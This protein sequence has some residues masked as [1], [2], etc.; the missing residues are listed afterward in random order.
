MSVA[1]YRSRLLDPVEVCDCLKSCVSDG[2]SPE[3][4]RSLKPEACTNR[5]RDYR[6]YQRQD[7]GVVAA[8][9]GR[10]KI[11]A[12]RPCIQFRPRRVD[13]AHLVMHVSVNGHRFALLPTLDGRHVAF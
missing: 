7:E 11:S 8:L 12:A 10:W 9:L 4:L 13:R 6:Q 2:A 1:G 5:Q 3:V